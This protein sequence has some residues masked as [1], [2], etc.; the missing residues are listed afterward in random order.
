MNSTFDFSFM[1]IIVQALPL[2][3]ISQ[4]VGFDCVVLLNYKWVIFDKT[5]DSCDRH[6]IHI[7]LCSNS[8][9]IGSILSN[10]SD[11][12]DFSNIFSEISFGRTWMIQQ[13]NRIRFTQSFDWRALFWR[14]RTSAR[15]LRIFYHL[16]QKNVIFEFSQRCD[17]E[18]APRAEVCARQIFFGNIIRRKFSKF[19]EK[20]KFSKKNLQF[21][22]ALKNSLFELWPNKKKLELD[23]AMSMTFP[24]KIWRARTSARGARSISHRCENSKITFFWHRW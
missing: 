13:W 19:W 5:T 7:A 10:I 16:C 6:I 4:F 2:L 15:A 22:I 18:R 3:L 21:Q 12:T 20:M 17:I 1:G 23:I 24:K 14:A 9:L 8:T 11:F